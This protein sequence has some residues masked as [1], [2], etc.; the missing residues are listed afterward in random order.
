MT[1]LSSV[2]DRAA[3]LCGME[4]SDVKRDSIDSAH[5]YTSTDGRPFPSLTTSLKIGAH[6]VQ[7]DTLL[8][9]KQQAFDR[10]KIQECIVHP[11]GSSAFGKFTVTHDVSKLTKAKLFQP[12]TVTPCYTRFSTVTLGREYPDSA[13]NPRGFATKFYTPDGNYDMVGL[14]WPIF[15][16]RDPWLGPDNI[17]S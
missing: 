1:Q 4:R 12:G 6:P 2:R 5:Q 11:A 9:E 8:L 14:N 15:F 13:R 16:V 17:R 7:S 3:A 10:M